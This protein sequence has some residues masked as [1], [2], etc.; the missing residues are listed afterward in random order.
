MEETG[1]DSCSFGGRVPTLPL[2]RGLWDS[3]WEGHF[4]FENTG[5]AKEEI[6]QFIT[7]NMEVTNH[8][9]K[10]NLACLGLFSMAAHLK[11]VGDEQN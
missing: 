6:S 10:M 7:I 5:I 9:I 2:A 1:S 4:P 3:G 11:W 8:P